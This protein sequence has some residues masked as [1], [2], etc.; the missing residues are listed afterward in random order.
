MT[1]L[2]NAATPTSTPP[3]Y[4]THTKR[5]TLGDE[6]ERDPNVGTEKGNIR[7]GRRECLGEEPMKLCGKKR[8]E[9]RKQ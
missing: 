1:F 9:T 4:Y 3:K 5:D 2:S 6:R 8:T 7:K